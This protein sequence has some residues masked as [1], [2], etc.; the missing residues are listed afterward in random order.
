[1]YQVVHSTTCCVSHPSRPVTGGCCV[2]HPSRPATGGCCVSHP[3]RPVTGGCCVSHPSRPVTGGYCVSHPSRP[4]T[5]GCCV[6]HPS[7]PITGG[8]HRQLLNTKLNPV[9]STHATVSHRFKHHT[10]SHG[11]TQTSL[12]QIKPQTY[13]TIFNGIK[14]MPVSTGHMPS[15]AI[16]S[17][18]D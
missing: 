8:C 10:L 12:H 11:L 16:P 18:R 9:P 13:T 5:G 3:S 15:H 2:S 14:S 7:R 6:S 1:M 4:V 17:H